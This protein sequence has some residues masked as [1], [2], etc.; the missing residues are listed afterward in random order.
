MYWGWSTGGREWLDA[1]VAVT[2]TFLLNGTLKCWI[3]IEAGQRLGE[4]QRAGALEL[5][6]STPLTG[7]DIV[8][9]QWLALR[10]QFLKPFL[11]VLAVEF[12][13][14]V[15][16]WRPSIRGG[17][18]RMVEFFT[19]AMILLPVDALAANWVAMRMAL[20]ARNPHRATAGAIFQVLILPWIGCF[21]LA[22]FM[23]ALAIVNDR[24]LPRSGLLGYTALWLWF[25]CGLVTDLGF[26]LPA[27]RALLADFRA[28]ATRRFAAIRPAVAQ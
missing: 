26:G 1:S 16:Y 27:L 3:I 6:L 21:G 8:R 7:R 4:Y 17:G 5:L 22:F 23:I 25:V 2:L 28:L 12:V 24:N 9:G 14:M 13:F 10:R 11:L 18:P 15:T 19:F 20:T